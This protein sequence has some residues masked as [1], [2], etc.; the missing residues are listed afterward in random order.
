MKSDF[1]G[2][3]LGEARE[4]RRRLL[5]ENVWESTR[6]PA[7]TPPGECRAA[8]NCGKFA[9]KVR[10]VIDT[11]YY[12]DLCQAQSPTP[13]T[14]STYGQ[15]ADTPHTAPGQFGNQNKKFD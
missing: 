10:K 14:T 6:R 5:P 15:E 4:G 1:S 13:V 3:T 2:R 9:P 8:R 11:L 7:A 12:E